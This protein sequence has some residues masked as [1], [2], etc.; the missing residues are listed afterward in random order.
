MKRSLTRISF[1]LLLAGLSLGWAQNPPANPAQNP[2]TPAVNAPGQTPPV[3]SIPPSAERLRPNYVLQEG[4]QVMLRAQDVEEINDRPFRIDSQGEVNFPLIGRLKASGLS[5]EQFERNV[6]EAL[7]RFIV[8]PQVTVI[9]TQ[10]KNDPVFVVGA[11]RAPGIYPL[12]GRRQLIDLMTAVGGLAPNTTRRIKVTRRIEAGRIP[13]PNV[14]T[15][16]D[17]KTTSVEISLGNLQTT[18]NPAEDI[19]LEPY[20]IISAER[21]EMVYLSGAVSR[22]GGIELGD[23]ESLSMLQA[24]AMSGGLAFNAKPTHAVILRPVLNTARRAVI[25]VDLKKIIDAQDNDYPLL[26]N[27]V[28]FVPNS[29]RPVLLRSLGNL[30]LGAAGAFVFILAGRL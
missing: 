3:N 4:D 30:G 1:A 5:I 24:L 27:D 29:V 17:G 21:A 20:D 22:I 19:A 13:L 16:P 9:V 14:T 7:R 18:I 23:R 15:S 6:T 8:N 12:T 10:F 2:A 28:L 25:P 26:P 11:F